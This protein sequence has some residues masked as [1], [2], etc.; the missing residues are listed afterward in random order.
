MTFKIGFCLH[1]VFFMARDHLDQMRTFHLLH[2]CYFGTV[3]T[4]R[5]CI[6]VISRITN[7]LS[8]KVSQQSEL[9][10]TSENRST[11]CQSTYRKELARVDN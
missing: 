2:K 11:K 5:P 10:A 4:V 8:Q 3:F 6:F 9:L 1:G 7:N